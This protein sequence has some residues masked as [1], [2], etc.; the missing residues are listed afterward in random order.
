MRKG[1]QK[2]YCEIGKKEGERILQITYVV[3]RPYLY[4]ALRLFFTMYSD[5]RF[6]KLPPRNVSIGGD[7]NEVYLAFS[8]IFQAENAISIRQRLEPMPEKY[9]LK[10]I[11]DET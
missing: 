8:A 2:Y 9:K 7:G 5:F 4:D 11:V 1:I 3:D 6:L 10:W